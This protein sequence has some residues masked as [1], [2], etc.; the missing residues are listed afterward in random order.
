[1][2]VLFV[3][4]ECVP[5]VKTGGLADVV[6]A[7]PGAFAGTGVEA[8]V[9]LPAYAGLRE[10]LPRRNGLKVRVLP[11]LEATVHRIEA[12][13]LDLL[14]LDAPELYDRPGNPYLGAD[15]RDWPDNHRRY[16][17]LSRAGAAIARDGHRGWRPQLVHLH[18]WQA[19]L[20]P[21]FM[22]ADGTGVPSV[23]T[24]HNIAFQ[25]VFEA[26][27]VRELDLPGQW[28]T[29]DGYEYYGKINMLKAGLVFA[30]AITTVSPTY[31]R[32]LLLPQFGMGLEGVLAGRREDLH[33]ILNGIDTQAWDPAS[34]PHVAANYSARAVGAKKINKAMVEQRFG[35]EPG[36]DTPLFCVISRLTEQKGI[37]LLIEAL[38]RLAQFGARLVV[39]GSGEAALE[40]ALLEASRQYSGRIGVILGYDEPLSHLIQAGCD[41]IVVPSRFEPCGLTQLYGLRYGTIPVVART[42]GLADTVIDA[43]HAALTSKSATGF[44]F[45]PGSAS[46]LRGALERACLLY[47][48]K[49][50]WRALMRSAMRQDV[51]WETSAK[52]YKALYQS[53]ISGKR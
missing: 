51:G 52:A 24:V 33:G 18:D 45:D 3:A 20:Q 40:Q 36:A 32:E 39:L 25:G 43:N 26:Q 4:S 14:L 21:L 10:L 22:Q 53:L 5:F 7:L 16:C 41:A 38:P 27:A 28:F 9:L 29:A 50:A 34:D 23:L 48:Q 49:S 6:G 15:G 47:G 37:D 44:V 1:M 11:D 42:G 8:A 12:E 17:A 30:D 13:G 35:L 31:A 46:S 2:R 19:G